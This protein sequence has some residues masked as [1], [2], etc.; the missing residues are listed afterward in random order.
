L[1]S[2]DAAGAA[3]N[4]SGNAW[5]ERAPLLAAWADRLLVNR[6][7]AWGGYKPVALRDDGGKSLTKPCRAAR[8]RVFLTPGILTRHF[9]GQRPEHVV[10]LHVTAP[11]SSCRWGA[12]DLDCHAAGDDPRATR[13]AA[14]AW[15]AK[16]VA[17]GFHPL[18]TG[19]DGKGGYHL[20]VIFDRP[21]PS[22]LV[23]AFMLWL[24]ADSASHG[25]QR[26][27]ECFPKQPHLPPGKFGHWLRLP[28]RHHTSGYW[29]RLWDGS[30]VLADAEAVDTLLSLTGDDPGRIPPGVEPPRPPVAVTRQVTWPG[31]ALTGAALAGRARAEAARIGARRTGWRSNGAYALAAF[32]TRDLSLTVE[33]SLPWL[34]EWNQQ[35]TPPLT[36]DEL[37]AIAAHADAYGTHERGCGLAPL[38]QRCHRRRRRAETIAFVA[39]GGDR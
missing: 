20:R 11:D 30:R 1:T 29:S 18:L 27:P 3:G 7:D 12:A 19:S 34:A 24:T 32:L 25:L 31:Q 2:I 21:I 14:L 23:Y 5:A 6:H 16:L 10:G 15:Y 35:N 36:G 8:G 9:R 38:T 13:R 28:G 39:K 22:E 17:L 4:L 26:R 37:A 33:E